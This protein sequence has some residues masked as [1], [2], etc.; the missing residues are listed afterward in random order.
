M[1]KRAT[2]RLGGQNASK[3]GNE[4]MSSAIVNGASGDARSR[5]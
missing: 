4:G 1:Y 5:H 2:E 3:E